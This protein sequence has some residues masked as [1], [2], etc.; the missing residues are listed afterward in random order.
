MKLMKFFGLVTA[1][2][3]ITGTAIAS[4]SAKVTV[5]ILTPTSNQ[6]ATTSAFVISGSAHASGN[7]AGVF[8][9]LNSDGWTPASL[10]SGGKSWYAVVTLTPGTNTPS[11]YA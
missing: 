5:Q 1:I 9:Q 7:I 2:V 8:Y 3:L 6:H 11:V 4:G 10:V